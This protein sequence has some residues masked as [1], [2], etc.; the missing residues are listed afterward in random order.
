MTDQQLKEMG[1]HW[2]NLLFLKIG[3]QRK[4]YKHIYRRLFK[5]RQLGG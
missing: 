1:K 2:Q 3:L 5:S 4:E